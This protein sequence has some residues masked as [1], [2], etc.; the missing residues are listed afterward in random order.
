MVPQ[1]IIYTNYILKEIEWKH[2]PHF[3]N[4]CICHIL[5]QKFL[6]TS[7]SL[8]FLLENRGS[9]PLIGPNEKWKDVIGLYNCQFFWHERGRKLPYHQKER[10]RDGPWRLTVKE[11]LFARLTKDRGVLTKRTFENFSRKENSPAKG[12]EE[13]ERALCKNPSGWCP[14]PGVLNLFFTGL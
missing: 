1:G 6:P 13:N 3:K 4:L 5:W 12:W 7:N 14:F 11:T 8:I 10:V 2:K 9:P